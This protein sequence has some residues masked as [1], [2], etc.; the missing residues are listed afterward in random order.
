MAKEKRTP[1]E[2]TRRYKS[3]DGTIRYV[4][5]NQLHNFDGPALIPEG[6]TR[7]AEYFVFGIPYTKEKFDESAIKIL[8]QPVI[9][10]DVDEKF[11][12]KN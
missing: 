5:F 11:R 7:K 9:E 10:T 2:P 1:I 6:N 12:V 8:Q 4:K 3:P